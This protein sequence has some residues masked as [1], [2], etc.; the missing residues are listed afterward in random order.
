MG[1]S[2]SASVTLLSA[3]L[4]GAAVM[5]PESERPGECYAILYYR[6]ATV[7]S[8]CVIACDAPVRQRKRE[9]EWDADSAPLQ[10]YVRHVLCNPTV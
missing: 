10:L 7:L 9:R 6:A 3:R 8:H 4:L 5:R 1:G 2:Y